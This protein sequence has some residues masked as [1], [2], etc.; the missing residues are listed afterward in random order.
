MLKFKNESFKILQIADTQEG[1][2]V[3][4]DTLDLINSSLDKVK[5]DLVVYSGD[6]IWG[7]SSFKGNRDLVKSTLDTLT[8]PVRE[9]KIPFSICFGNHDRQVGLSNDEQLE[10]YKELDGFIGESVKGIDG[11]A[12]HVLEIWDG[13]ELKFLLYLIDSNTSLSVG[14]DNVHENQINWYRETRD[15]YQEKYGRL[16]PS[17][18]IQHIPVCEIFELL[19]EVKKN[20]KG[21]VRGFR[22]HANRFYVLNKEKVNDGGFM[23]ESPAD[24]QVNSGEFSAF[25]EKG[26]VLGVYF[27]HDHNNSFNGKVDG[28]DLGYTQGAGFHVYG[29]GKDRG[30]RVI[31]LYRDSSFKTYDLRFKDLVGKKLKEPLHYAFY[32][33]MPTNV[34]DAVHRLIKFLVAVGIVTTVAVVIELLKCIM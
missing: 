7:Y 15:N 33:I 1:K 25:K 14:Y 9:R 26:E 16:I 20:T 18:V 17:I 2:R 12:N 24:P 32:Q 19:T 27:G 11:C 22:T 21:S 23:K 34:Y 6:Q 5:P 13:D 28:I 4:P 31:E 10:I 30:V 3:S 8:K 29:P